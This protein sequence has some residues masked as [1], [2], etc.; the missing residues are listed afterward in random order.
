MSETLSAATR[1][2]ALVTIMVEVIVVVVVV[3]PSCSVGSSWAKAKRERRVVTATSGRTP[4]VTSILSIIVFRRKGEIKSPGRF[5]PAQRQ[6]MQTSSPTF[7]R[8]EDTYLQSVM[9]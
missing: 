2:R 6:E 7:S 4:N 5:L 9:A 1:E 3:V 8:A